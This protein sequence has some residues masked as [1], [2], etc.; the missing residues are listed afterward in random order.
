MQEMVELLVGLQEE[1]EQNE[2]GI[3]VMMS[4]D[5]EEEIESENDE[6]RA[7]LDD[8]EETEEDGPGFYRALDRDLEAIQEE[9]VEEERHE[10]TEE[11]EKKKP[12]PLVK[13]KE[14]LEVY[15]QELPVL[16]FNN[17]RYDLNMVKEFLLPYLVKNEAVKF[18][19]KINNNNMCLTTDH[20]KFL[21]ITNYLARGFDYDQFLKAYECEASKG[22]LSYEWLDDISCKTRPYSTSPTCCLLLYPEKHQ[23]ND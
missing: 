4:D 17:G 1:S 5:E 21:D 7:F 2:R 13:L 23:H 10:E 12:Y 22:F 3:D 14:K 6:D 11:Q 9:R 18:A 20:L 8:G 15:L 16:G 19:I